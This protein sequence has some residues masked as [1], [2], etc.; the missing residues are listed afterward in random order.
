M[1]FRET[2]NSFSVCDLVWTIGLDFL[3]KFMGVNAGNVMAK[4]K[5]SELANKTKQHN[6]G[7]ICA[8]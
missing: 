2:S 5:E 6:L 7:D 8:I 3:K 1:R 4:F